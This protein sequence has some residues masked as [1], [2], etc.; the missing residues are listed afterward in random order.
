[1]EGWRQRR[2]GW[3]SR[4]PQEERRKTDLTLTGQLMEGVSVDTAVSVKM[5]AVYAYKAYRIFR[6]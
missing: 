4:N 2:L 6:R 5:L 3:N 1:V